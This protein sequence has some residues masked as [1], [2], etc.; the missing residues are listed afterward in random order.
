MR[1]SGPS[2]GMHS[3]TTCALMRCLMSSSLARESGRQASQDYIESVQ[4]VCR[5]LQGF[6][7]RTRHSGSREIVPMSPKT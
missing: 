2:F 7:M 5:K 6:G 1:P 4:R 3:R